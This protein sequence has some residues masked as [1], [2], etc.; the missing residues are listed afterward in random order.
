MTDFIGTGWAFP[1]GFEPSGSVSMVRGED[2]IEQAMRL[3]LSTYPGE[4]PMRPLWGSTLRDNVFGGTGQ[5]NIAAIT[6]EVERSLEY[7]EPRA[8]V[9]EV[10]V[11]PDGGVDGLLYID[12]KYTVRGANSPRNLVF[13]FYTIPEHS[14]GEI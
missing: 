5:D 10:L 6:R 12:I 13:P 3:I 8:H 11:Y 9:R 7:A 14:E 4:R 2:K 1:L